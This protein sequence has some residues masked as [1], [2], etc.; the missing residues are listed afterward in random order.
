ME[1]KMQTNNKQITYYSDILL[2]INSPLSCV[3]CNTNDFRIAVPNA[4]N[5]CKCEDKYYDDGSNSLC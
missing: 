3:S 2:I 5:E 4:N 1:D